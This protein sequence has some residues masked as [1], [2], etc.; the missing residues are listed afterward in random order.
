MNN[1]YDPLDHS[2]LLCS[3][4]SLSLAPLARAAFSALNTI[5]KDSKLLDLKQDGDMH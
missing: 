4:T 2:G 5:G 1:I 3:H